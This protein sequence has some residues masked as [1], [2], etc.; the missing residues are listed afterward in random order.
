MDFKPD[1]PGLDYVIFLGLVYTAYDTTA[2]FWI[3]DSNVTSSTVLSL[4]NFSGVLFAFGTGPAFGTA[5]TPTSADLG[6]N[7]IVTPEPSTITIAL[8][9]FF[10]AGFLGIRRHRRASKKDVVTLAGPGE[11]TTSPVFDRHLVAR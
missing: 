9:G 1:S 8:S 3:A 7:G 10:A 11:S 6:P 5:G 4:G 2:T